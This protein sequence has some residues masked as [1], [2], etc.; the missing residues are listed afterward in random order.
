MID[1]SS[2][3]N[4]P[5]NAGFDFIIAQKYHVNSDKTE[6]SEFLYKK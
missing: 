1:S 6:I 3:E 4:E 5:E 2:F